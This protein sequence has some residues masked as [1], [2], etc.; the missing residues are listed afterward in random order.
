MLQ[1]IAKLMRGTK[2]VSR[3]PNRFG[4]NVFAVCRSQPSRTYFPAPAIRTPLAVRA[5]L[6]STA[7]FVVL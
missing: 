6:V 5:G 1:I 7:L 3:L 2:L 4:A